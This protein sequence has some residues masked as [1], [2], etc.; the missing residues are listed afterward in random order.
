MTLRHACTGDVGKISVSSVTSLVYGAVTSAHV[1]AR[2]FW[3]LH[4]YA[5]E[6]GFVRLNVTVWVGGRGGT[7][8]VVGLYVRRGVFPS[9]T[10]YDIFHAIDVDKLR[11]MLPSSAG[12]GRTRRAASNVR[13]LLSLYLTISRTLTFLKTLYRQHVFPRAPFFFPL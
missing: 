8:A 11:D 7:G 10:R 5:A 1:S 4:L 2:D 3:P 9:H 13:N 12:D 6:P